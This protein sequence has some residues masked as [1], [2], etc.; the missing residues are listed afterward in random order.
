M[1]GV[2]KQR[3]IPGW[4]AGRDPT[5][6]QPRAWHIRGNIRHQ[7]ARLSNWSGKDSCQR[8]PWVV[9]KRFPI[10][11]ICLRGKEAKGHQ[12]HFTDE[13]AEDLGDEVTW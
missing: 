1:C 2:R 4:R 10:F 12:L 11:F 5:K 3:W 8:T 9:S 7:N 6:S 13:E